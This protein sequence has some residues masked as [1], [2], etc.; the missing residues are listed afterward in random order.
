EIIGRRIQ[1]GDVDAGRVLVLA[2][3]R[4]LGY[5]VRDALNALGVFA[6]SFFHE[7]ALDEVDAQ[8]A[9]TLLTLLVNPEDRVALRCWCGFGSTPLRSGAWVRLR[10]HCE[11]SGQGPLAALERLASGAL[12]IPHTGPL[13]ERFKELQ[14]RLGE[15]AP[16]RGQALVDALFPGDRDW[17]SF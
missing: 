4:Q 3:R 17:T 2:P 7:E 8:Q 5:A 16:A 10:A 15:L 9:F 6:H 13:V 12:T 1:H 14:T 11:T